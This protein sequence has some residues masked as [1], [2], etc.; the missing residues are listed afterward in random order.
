M[1]D[2]LF[3]ETTK[4]VSDDNEMFKRFKEKMPTNEDLC[5]EIANVLLSSLDEVSIKVSFSQLVGE[6]QDE[7]YL[8]YKQ[9]QRQVG[10]Q[11]L[12]DHISQRGSISYDA[13]DSFFLSISQSRKS[14][15]GGVFEYIIQELFRRLS[16]PAEAQ[17]EID[18]AKPDFVLPS[19]EYFR[20][21][22]LDSLIFTAKRTLR[23][24][25]RQVVTEANK[26][27]GYFLATI[28]EKISANQIAKASEN[29]IYIVTTQ[30]NIDG[31]PHYGKAYSVI[32][33]EDFFTHHLDPAM[34]R[35]DL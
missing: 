4:R 23:E 29:K 25:W 26:G 28:D 9:A 19:A 3:T 20:E 17:V 31:N 14:R 24:R 33:F 18:G 11:I 2:D 27:Y 32:S 13:L 7:I 12:D 22:P 10:Q 21:K 16:Y 15:A 35:W 30:Q 34:K 5:H 1:Q 6:M 8:K